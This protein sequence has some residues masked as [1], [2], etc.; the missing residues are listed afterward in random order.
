MDRSGVVDVRRLGDLLRDPPVKLPYWIDPI[1]PKGGKLLF[2][3]NAKVGKS[4]FLLNLIRSLV[5][6]ETTCGIPGFKASP[7]KVLLV[8]QELGEIGLRERAAGIY[9]GL[10]EVPEFEENAWYVSREPELTFS[11]DKGF[12]KLREIVARSMPE[13]LVLDPMGK[14]HTYDENDATNMAVLFQRVD[15]LLKD[16]RDRGMSIVMSQHFG[17][18]PKGVAA[19]DHDPLEPYN[20]RG[21]GKWK[22]DP[23][24]LITMQRLP[25]NLGTPWESWKTKVRYMLR[26]ASCPPDMFLKFNEHGDGRVYWEKN[27]SPPVSGPVGAQPVAGTGGFAVPSRR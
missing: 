21:S 4:W 27:D 3:G 14:L 19:D 8:E 22:D 16:G 11:T 6:G 12:G 26:H 5:L 18:P 20:F 17:K 13:V 25:R 24:S 23:D 9:D 7:A 1:L 2:G 10:A 15:T